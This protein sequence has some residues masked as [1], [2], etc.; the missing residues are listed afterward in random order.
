MFQK[1]QLQRMRH[2]LALLREPQSTIQPRAHFHT[3]RQFSLRKP[4]IAGSKGNRD[5][6]T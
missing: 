6:Q 1:L 4:R 2:V 3:R 5:G